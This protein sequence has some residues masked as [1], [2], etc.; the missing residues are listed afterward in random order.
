MRQGDKVVGTLNDRINTHLDLRVSSGDMEFE[1]TWTDPQVGTAAVEAITM[2]EGTL[3]VFLLEDEGADLLMSVSRGS[4]GSA[5]GGGDGRN[6]LAGIAQ[7]DGKC[8]SM[9]GQGGANAGTPVWNSVAAPFG[10]RQKERA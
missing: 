7:R 6:Q 2:P 3:E 1:G 10:S 4:G 5:Q 9:T 8:P